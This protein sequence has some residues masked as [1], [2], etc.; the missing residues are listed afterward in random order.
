MTLHPQNEFSIP[1]ETV[2]VARAA[3]PKGNLSLKYALGLELTD[4][5]FDFPILSDFRT[6]LIDGGG[7]QLL[8][9]AMLNLF[10]ER[11][12]LKERQQQ[13][14]DSTHISREAPC[15]QS[16]PLC[17]RSHAL[18]AQQ[19]G[20]RCWQLVACSCSGGVD[21]SVWASHGRGPLVIDWEHQQ[22]T[23]PPSDTPASVG[24][25]PLTT[26]RTRSSR[27]ASLLRIAKSALVRSI[28]PILNREF[29]VV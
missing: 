8:L 15:D 27:S 2:R 29:L 24:L 12:W 4:P 18:C 10:K 28:V 22:A 1:E 9:D 11:G 17:W 16:A 3:Y 25:R 21:L 19:F 14:T 23:C 7:E 5:G 26:R 13:R 20:C 6:R